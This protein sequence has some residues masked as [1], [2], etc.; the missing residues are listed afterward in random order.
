MHI[1]IYMYTYIICIGHIGNL[2]LGPNLRVQC[3]V[4]RESLRV[5][6]HTVRASS[7]RSASLNSG[8]FLSLE[9]DK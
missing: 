1:Y 2:D 6:V 5:L 4:K 7:G 3:E 9:P 8:L